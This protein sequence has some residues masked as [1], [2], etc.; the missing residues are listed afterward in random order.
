MK[1]ELR[2]VQVRDGW[3]RWGATTVSTTLLAGAVALLLRGLS[4]AS[5]AVEEGADPRSY[6]RR[7]YVRLLPG[8]PVGVPVEDL[9]S[10]A[11]ASLVARFHDPLQQAEGCE[12][13]VQVSWIDGAGRS[14]GERRWRRLFRPF[15]LLAP[16]LL[17]D[18]FVHPGGGV[19]SGTQN[20]AVDAEQIPEGARRIE[21]A[22]AGPEGVDLYARFLTKE[23]FPPGSFATGTVPALRRDLALAK[24][25]GFPL[26]FLPEELLEASRAWKWR[27]LGVQPR[28]GRA[29]EQHLLKR[30]LSADELRRIERAQA[31]PS[32][33][34]GGGM[35][36]RGYPVSYTL[37]IPGR[38][39]L[40]C[41]E[42][43]GDAGQYRIERRT[44]GEI[45]VAR[46]VPAGGRIL[47]EESVTAPTTLIVRKESGARAPM[48]MIRVADA[49]VTEPLFARAGHAGAVAV[50]AGPPRLVE[51]LRPRGAGA[52]SG[53]R[54]APG[55]LVF[56]WS[57]EAAALRPLLR[58]RL[59]GLGYP[60]PG[61][62]RATIALRRD[63]GDSSRS[64]PLVFPVEDLE[65]LPDAWSPVYAG[66]P[67]D[68]HVEVPEDVRRVEISFDAPVLAAAHQTLPDL[69]GV[70]AV[71]RE[72]PDRSV[73]FI[74]PGDDEEEAAGLFRRW[75]PLR[76]S[77][78]EAFASARASVFLNLQ[79]PLIR[80]AEP[81]DRYRSRAEA[82]VV[83]HDGDLPMLWPFRPLGAPLLRGPWLGDW[84]ASAFRP[85]R[86][87][88]EIPRRLDDPWP[89]PV[90]LIRPGGG[91]EP[92]RA[93]FLEG[94]KVAGPGWINTPAAAGDD[95]REKALRHHRGY[96][97]G[98][99]VPVELV[100]DQEEGEERFLTVL[101]QPE[102]P[103]PAPVLLQVEIDR[104]DGAAHPAAWVG[105][106][107]RP[108]YRF[109]F[110]LREAGPSAVP[111]RPGVRFDAPV[112]QA[113]LLVGADLLPG[114]YRAVIRPLSQPGLRDRVVL[115]ASWSSQHP[116]RVPP[117]AAH[118]FR[119]DRSG[120]SSIG[121]STPS[122]MRVFVQSFDGR[123]EP[124]HRGNGVVELP[125]DALS[126][127]AV[128]IDGEA[129][130]PFVVMPEYPGLPPA[131]RTRVLGAPLL[132][133]AERW[134]K[135]E[136]SWSSDAA[137]APRRVRFA[138][139][140]DAAPPLGD[141]LVAGARVPLQWTRAPWAVAPRWPARPVWFSDP[142]D[143]GGRAT[144]QS[145]VDGLWMRW[146]RRLAPAAAI[147]LHVPRQLRWGG[148]APYVVRA[149]RSSG[150]WAPDLVPEARRTS[151]V[152]FSTP[153][154]YRADPALAL[155]PDLTVFSKPVPPGDARDETELVVKRGEWDGWTR[156]LDLWRRAVPG[157]EQKVRLGDPSG[158]TRY[159]GFQAAWKGLPLDGGLRPRFELRV[160]GTLRLSEAI[161]TGTGRF[162]V[163][164]LPAGERQVLL[165]VNPNPGGEWRVRTLD[166]PTD[167]DLRA[168]QA[169]IDVA[170]PHVLRLDPLA[171]VSQL[172]VQTLA[173]APA[174]G[175]A[176]WTAIWL[177]YVPFLGWMPTGQERHWILPGS[178]E[179]FV[180]EAG[181]GVRWRPGL[182]MAWRVEP[183]RLRALVLAGP[184][185]GRPALRAL[186]TA[187]EPFPRG[188]FDAVRREGTS[189]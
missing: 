8:V 115:A 27:T 170:P 176:A 7:T 91:P 182:R 55:A 13:E 42:S 90:E 54:P 183:G 123:V 142:V 149:W 77:N 104:A 153:T 99:Q 167:D 49:K 162:S 17:P 129:S 126:V 32:V 78:E 80:L 136:G 36:G 98:P 74:S 127:R 163:P 152:T 31:L 97:A 109:L 79:A 2:E 38:Y 64:V 124:L 132:E 150:L 144:L 134:E 180:H 107:T 141:V 189:R 154:E 72:S 185:Q 14:L 21:F 178:D 138:W 106:Y 87:G 148:L 100:F 164:D 20:L 83:R 155:A 102:G 165:A 28:R 171:R 117:G 35:A 172:N 175:V 94:G 140:D 60:P 160:D 130:L 26:D 111:L 151:T 158:G 179:A 4:A 146:E 137:P 186:R 57:A 101:V 24:Q 59:R 184:S 73:G 95:P 156:A 143:V 82:E 6:L 173:T 65:R 181:D 114:R 159:A 66:G 52:S 125:A 71:R 133:E 10:R 70:H 9:R 58:V 145:A 121:V 5:G 76:P 131:E 30:V 108:R 67:V 56:E 96:R 157:V 33:A 11:L 105:P 88:E 119:V 75:F 47:W 161:L 3:R 46:L 187:A 16:G 69:A 139:I 48:V 120:T 166:R 86:P 22:L 174:E 89:E 18:L 43:Q 85:A 116:P 113:R 135:L 34:R 29:E 147:S 188:P 44:E 81:P 122:N 103:A 25:A 12:I 177:D 50:I 169:W 92:L 118:S 168:V 110:D 128:N 93:L 51:A 62:V 39:R 15:H 84:P 37:D 53:L 68:L 112:F 19:L 1:F 45:P 61:A 41:A 40:E 23:Y 63:A